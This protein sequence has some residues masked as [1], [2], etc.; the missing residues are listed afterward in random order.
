MIWSSQLVAYLVD[1]AVTIQTAQR[2]K[3]VLTV[4][5]Y[6][7]SF[8]DDIESDQDPCRYCFIIDQ[9][10]N[11]DAEPSV[12]FLGFDATGVVRCQWESG[13]IRTFQSVNAV[14]VPEAVEIGKPAVKPKKS[15][16]G[17]KDEANRL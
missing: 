13:A 2:K 9:G 3:A 4:N 15:V 8:F 7:A 1:S 14:V 11:D 6:Q 16:A 17:S 5:R 12:V 10:I